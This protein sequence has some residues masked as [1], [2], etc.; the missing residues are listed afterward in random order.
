[1][2]EN[3]IRAT[4]ASVESYLQ[5]IPDPARRKD[6]EALSR[7]MPKATKESPRMWGSPSA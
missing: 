4:K 2:A 1:M 6:C 5:I 7:L 3:K